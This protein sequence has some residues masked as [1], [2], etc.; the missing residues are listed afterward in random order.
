MAP[1]F[2][3]VHMCKSGYLLWIN[4][5]CLSFH[6]QGSM[7]TAAAAQIASSSKPAK[8]AGGQ[9][10]VGKSSKPALKVLRSTNQ[11]PSLVSGGCTQHAPLHA[12]RPNCWRRL[13][14][15]LRCDGEQREGDA[16]GG[17][18]SG[19]GAAAS[20]SEQ[21]G[22]RTLDPKTLRRLAQ[23]REAARKSRLRKKVINLNPY[24]TYWWPFPP[25]SSQELVKSTL[26]INNK[27]EKKPCKEE[28]LTNTKTKQ[29]GSRLYACCRVLKLTCY[30]RK[31][32]ICFR[33]TTWA[34]FNV[35]LEVSFLLHGSED[36]LHINSSYSS[37]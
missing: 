33:P 23:N 11:S 25:L 37:H 27:G 14:T 5:L 4:D 2:F 18:K 21:E 12:R 30:L 20:S 9:L 28:Q 6:H 36:A 15:C 16:A 3:F 32:S 7:N 35:S 34:V 13:K 29:M 17:S 19:G 1:W 22:P 26:E 24:T 10:A 31:Y 8:A